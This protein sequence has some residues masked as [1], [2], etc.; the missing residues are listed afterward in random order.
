MPT[1][2]SRATLPETDPCPVPED[3]LGRLY[4][5]GHED[6]AEIVSTLPEIQRA[7]LA[8]FCY[9]RAHLSD[10]GRVIASTCN[11]QV[12][13]D[14]ADQLGSVLYAQSRHLPAAVAAAVPWAH[15]KVTLAARSAPAPLPQGFDELQDNEPEIQ[16]EERSEIG[17]MPIEELALISA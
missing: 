13:V 16:R 10:M 17:A 12:L 6:L 15:R 11:Q 14:V 2:A 4:R 7:R 9:G 1:Y 5:S 3:M 8:V